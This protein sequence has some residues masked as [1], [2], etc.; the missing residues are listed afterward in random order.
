MS[1]EHH[2]PYPLKHPLTATNLMAALE[3]K[4]I[5]ANGLYQVTPTNQA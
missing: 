2:R 1:A 4:E 3:D 5:F